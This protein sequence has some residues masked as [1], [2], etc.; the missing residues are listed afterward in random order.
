MIKAAISLEISIII[1]K[2]KRRHISDINFYMQSN[3][4]DFFFTHE[5]RERS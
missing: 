1:Y 3:N 2:V 5:Q 4:H